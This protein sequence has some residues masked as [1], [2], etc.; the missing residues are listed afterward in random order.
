MRAIHKLELLGFLV[1]LTPAVSFAACIFS[2]SA[3]NGSKEQVLSVSLPKTITAPRNIALGTVL[4]ESAAF[5]VGPTN[6]T[7]TETVPRGIKN[8]LGSTIVG[9][10]QFPIGDTGLSWEFF[11]TDTNQPNSAFGTTML[12]PRPP[13][14]GDWTMSGIQSE[15]AHYSY[16][17]HR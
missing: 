14:G 11:R 10:T 17:S 7:C 5:S 16:G 3:N 6:Y 2:A 13:S 8:N 4:Y 12:Q 15:V 9:A 1:L